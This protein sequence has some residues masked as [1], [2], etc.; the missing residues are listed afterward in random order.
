MDEFSPD[1]E[2][3]VGGNFL[4]EKSG[5]IVMTMEQADGSLWLTCTKT[6]EGYRFHFPELADF[7]I[8]RQGRHVTFVAQPKT[9]PETIRYLFLD[10]II[11]PLLNLRGRDALHASAVRTTS[12]ACAFI[13]PSGRGKSTLAAAFHVAGYPVLCD[14]CLLLKDDPDRV[15]VEPAY[16]GLRLWDDGLE[17]VLGAARSTLPVCHYNS[18]RRVSTPESGDCA[19]LPLRAVYA[20]VGYEDGDP[21]TAPLIEPLSIREAFMKLVECAFR[22]DLADRAMIL[23]QMRMLER[24]AKEVPVRRLRLPEDLGVLPAARELI[25][26]D[27]RRE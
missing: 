14:D 11:P 7:M 19:S 13:G 27:L 1:I 10:Q 24:V 2:L 22:F 23:R 25:L 20:L 18:K 9:S 21:L 15:L 16:P 8:D 3:D 26:Q 4:L 6:H 5:E 12:G 17:V